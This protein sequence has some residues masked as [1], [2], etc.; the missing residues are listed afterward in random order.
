VGCATVRCAAV[1]HLA[2]PITGHRTEPAIV[3]DERRAPDYRSD[4]P[5]DWYGYRVG[6]VL[7]TLSI[8]AASL[9]ACTDAG[10]RASG[11]DPRPGSAAA[12][13][14]RA[15]A[16]PLAARTRQPA[17]ATQVLTGAVT[18]VTT[19]DV[20]R[21]L[22]ISAPVVVVADPDRPA[23]LAA[24]ASQ[25]VRA[26]AP[27]LLIAAG[28]GSPSPAA[29]S[30]AARS[31]GTRPPGQAR[32]AAV[33]VSSAQRTEIENLHP[34]AVL[35]VGLAASALSAQLPGI[36]V[37]TGPG[38]LPAT[39]APPQLSHVAVL[40]AAGD[41]AATMA[42]TTTAEVAGA[43]VVPVRGN[44]PRADPVA[45][46]A[47]S[48]LRPQHVLAVGAGFGPA[49]Q[50][51]SRVAVAMT[52][53]QLPGGGQVVFPGRRLVALYG[54]PGAPALG[55]LGQ[56]D[57]PASLARARH[58]AASYRALSRV[59]VVPAFEIIATVA[60]ASSG[61]DGSYSA[62]S[63]VADLL[64]WVEKATAAGFYVILDL[65]PGRADLLSQAKLYEPLLRLPDVGLALDAEW[66]LQPGQLPLHQIGSV[67]AGEINR[68]ASWLAGLTAAYHLPQKLLVLHQ[69]RLSMIQGEQALDTRYDDLA[70]IVHM[71]GQGTPGMKQETWNAVTAAAPP[72]LFFGWKN[73]YTKDEPML[74]PAATMTKTPAPLMISYQ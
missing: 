58:L 59:P 74:S 63:S 61:A 55:A 35:A 14:S 33:T 2:D 43:A 68:V 51:A 50:L 49:A 3:P 28:R 23:A 64:P 16:A 20:A 30:S 60:Q 70:I 19:A 42:V 47:I 24:A 54:H 53:V 7:I 22:F 38:G 31:P 34:R 71:D 5:R 10:P 41:S 13:A 6:A 44:D 18:G 29:P 39:T 12:P 11:P 62:V 36:H 46:A 32:T 26:H 48:A 56:Q 40:V 67:G 69:F 37:I 65:Q 8:L 1:Q 4:G 57:L 52:G 45:I 15:A 66:K 9:T 27:L 17:P 25:A 21:Q 72:G 73:F